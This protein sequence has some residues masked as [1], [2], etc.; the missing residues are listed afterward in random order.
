MESSKQTFDYYTDAS[1]IQTKPSDPFPILGFSVNRSGS[2]SDVVDQ[3]SE[4]LGIT[5]KYDCKKSEFK[6]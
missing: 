5:K 1:V 3:E 6:V 4:L 2:N